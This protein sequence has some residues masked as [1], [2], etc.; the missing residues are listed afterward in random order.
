MCGHLL[1]SVAEINNKDQTSYHKIY[2]IFAHGPIINTL[3]HVASSNRRAFGISER[4]IFRQICAHVH[5]SHCDKSRNSSSIK[6][7]I[8]KVGI[9]C[10][11]PSAY[12]LNFGHNAV[13]IL[14]LMLRSQELH[15]ESAFYGHLTVCYD[16]NM[17]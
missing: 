8:A 17:K 3:K 5:C 13:I 11:G 9:L 7:A 14:P 15:N 6:N 4:Y 10:S 12:S 2:S 16:V 1:C